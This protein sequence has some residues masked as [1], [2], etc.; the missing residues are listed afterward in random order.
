MST[1]LTLTINGADVA[2]NEGQS[3]L[4]VALENDI[5]IPTMCHLDGLSDT[6]SCRLCV[7]EIAGSN[8]LAP[9]CTTPV[10]EGME[11]TT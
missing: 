4:S 11:I 1:V 5:H 3:V 10:A 2:G 7:V 9:A 6:G 8:K